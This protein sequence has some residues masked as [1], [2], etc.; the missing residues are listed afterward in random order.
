MVQRFSDAWL[1]RNNVV[2][3]IAGS[4][5]HW[6]SEG[7]RVVGASNYNVIDSNYVA[8]ISGTSA[9]VSADGYASWNTFKQNVVRNATYGFWDQFGGWGNEWLYN[10]AENN[11]WRSYQLSGGPAREGPSDLALRFTRL[12]CNFGTAKLNIRWVFDSVFEYNAVPEVQ[13]HPDQL[14]NW[15]SS[16]N[17]WDGSSLPPPKYPA[18]DK[19]KALCS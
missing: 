14:K 3:K 17:L 7:I 4:A 10:R 8:W 11:R 12:R 1:I 2:Q 5:V 19:Y 15:Q 13:V 6:V 16:G 9:G 18:S